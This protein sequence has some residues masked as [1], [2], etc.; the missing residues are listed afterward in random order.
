MF[1]VEFGLNAEAQ[2]FL[3]RS[4]KTLAESISAFTSEMNTL[5]NKTIE[6]TMINAKQYEAARSVETHIL[7]PAQYTGR[8]PL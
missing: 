2:N 8:H 7:F 4:G 3:S 5:V 6:D 1:Q